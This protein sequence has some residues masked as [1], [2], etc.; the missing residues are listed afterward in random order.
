MRD[1]NG[2]VARFELKRPAHALGNDGVLA[3]TATNRTW[4]KGGVVDPA[5]LDKLKLR[6]EVLLI[7]LKQQPARIVRATAMSCTEGSTKGY[8]ATQETMGLSIA[9]AVR[10]ACR[11][12]LVTRVRLADVRRKRTDSASR[13]RTELEIIV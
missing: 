6:F 2:R 12:K 5:L 7:A 3:G 13:V 10:V 1:W 8:P 11:G 4:R 9:F